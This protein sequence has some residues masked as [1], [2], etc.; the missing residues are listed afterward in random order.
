MIGKQIT[1]FLLVCSFPFWLTGQATTVFTDA[2]KAYKKGTEFYDLGLFAKAQSEFRKTIQ[3]LRPVIEPE[4]EV[5]RAKAELNIAKSAVQ[6]GQEDGEKLILDFVRKYEPEPIAKDAL[7]EIANYYYNAKEY[8]KAIE[9][10]DEVETAGM[11]SEE[12]SEVFFRKGY[13][14]FVQK[15]FKD[16]QES[17]STIKD[18]ENKYYYPTN[19]YLGLCYFYDGEYEQADD[20]FEVVERSEQYQPF[21]PFYRAQIY[22]AE[23]RYNDLIRYAEPRLESRRLRKKNEIRQLVGQAYFELQDYEKALP[24]L[25]YYAERSKRLREEEFYQLGYAQYKTENYKEAINSFKELATVDSR[26]GQNA[27]FYLADCYLRLG[28]RASARSAFADA[29]RMQYDPEIQEEALF[30][31]AKLSYELKDP[32]EAIT[33]LKDIP[34][35]SRYHTDA[36]ELMSEIFL[37]YRDYKQAMEIIEGLPN[38]TPQIRETYQ[39]VT[40]YRGLQL[41]QQQNL[42]GAKELLK[43]SLEYPLDNMT[44]AKATYW[45]GDIA[46]RQEEYNNSIKQINQFLTMAKA[47]SGLPDE[48]SLFT[49]NYIQGYNYLKQENYTAALGFFQEAVDGIQRNRTFIRNENIKR[50]ILGDATMR[51]GDCLFKR[52][53]YAGAIKFYDQAIN[54]RYTGFE[55]AIY[56]KAVIEGLRGRTTEKILAL[57]RIPREFPNSE[58]ADD[59]LLQLGSTYQ[60]IGQLSKAAEPLKQ[61]ISDYRSKSDLINQAIIRLGLINYNQGNLETAINYYKQIFANNPTPTEA[62]L[63]LNALEEIYVD[64]LGRADEYFAFLET[65][66]G[67]KLDNFAKDSINFKAAESQFENA[68]Y[69]RAVEGY[70]TYLRRFPNGRYTL[71]AHYHRG[72]SYSVLRKYSEALFDYEFVAD[73]GPSRYFLK[74]LEKAAIIAYNH[75]RD[76]NKAFDLYTRLESSAASQDQKFEAQLGALRSAYR[77]ADASSVYSLASKVANSPYATKLQQATANFYLGKMAFDQKDYPNAL[78]AF[79]QVVQLSDNEQTAEARYLIAYIRYLQRDL[80]TAQQLCINA[81]RESSG[82]PYWVAKSVILL[83][84]ILLEKNDLYNARAAL[85]ALLENFNEDPELVNTAQQKLNII[86]QQINRGSRLDNS[87]SDRLEMDNGNGGNDE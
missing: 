53:Q 42:P 80:E 76:F 29:K 17:F 79:Q 5:L 61:L 43:K 62:Q 20:I 44:T 37:S 30:N 8:E 55:Y 67:Y 81:N 57:E 35:S 10:Y 56:Q 82:Y 54:G 23:R 71:V 47:L 58:F 64:D 52:N 68:N 38:K 83:S 25:E 72:E 84:D 22:F 49:G 19:Y 39:K 6:L 33:A 16:A 27:M 73:Q 50:Q 36:Q 65:I 74:A 15:N 41:L 70:S 31:Y 18:N 66:P 60:S 34:L 11:T 85:E 12:K 75:E 87:N 13:S 14:N 4:A 26:L 21:I 86:N 9:Y 40:F 51:A 46:H 2:N 7:V 1:L 45:L 28:Q 63:A 59:A 32:R 48:S 77:V 3:L 69:D 24:N 78:T